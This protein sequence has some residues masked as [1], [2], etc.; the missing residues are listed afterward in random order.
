MNNTKINKY[1]FANN[2][3]LKNIVNNIIYGYE[4]KS[5]IYSFKIKTI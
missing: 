2:Q 5:Q 3:D 1:N 4:I